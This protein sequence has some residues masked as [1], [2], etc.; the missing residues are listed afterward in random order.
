M[1]LSCN[2][3]SKA[4]GV[5]QILSEVSFHIEDQEKTAIVG[6]NGAGK[7]TLLKIM[8]GELAADQ[9]EVV[10]SKGK[11]MGYLA[12]H[13][14]LDSSRSIYDELLEVKRPLIEM[15]ERIRNLE[16]SMKHADGQELQSMLQT[17]SQLNHEFELQNGYAYLSEVTG[18]LKGLGFEEAEFKKTVSA[19]SGGQKT[20]ESLGK[21]LLT[22]PDVILLDEPTNHLD[23]E[24][25]AWLETYLSNYNGSVIIVAHDRYFLDR[26]VR[27]IFS[28]EGDGKIRQYEGGYTDF[29]VVRESET[30]EVIPLKPVKNEEKDT[31]AGRTRERKLKFSYKEQREWETIESD[32]ADLEDELKELEIQIAASASDYSR[33]NVLMADKD[34]KELLLEEKMDRWMYLNELAQ[35][36]AEQE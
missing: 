30:Q 15:E 35:Q 31:S 36:I 21:L 34:T 28:F 13:Q 20:R 25:I 6:I 27:R 10:L 33:L 23:M 16:L 2:R 22:K 12:Q 26:A 11:T 18:V 8:I 32:I 4:F 1:I 3:I 19:L 5:D 17:Y 14:D 9:G 24:S 7:S 29:Q